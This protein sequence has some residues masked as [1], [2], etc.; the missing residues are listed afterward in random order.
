MEVG[1]E[2][3]SETLQQIKA[4]TEQTIKPKEGKPA[5]YKD[6]LER[7]I[8]NSMSLTADRLKAIELLLKYY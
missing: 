2:D 7:I 8:H 1:N 6:R 5:E 4:A 3:W